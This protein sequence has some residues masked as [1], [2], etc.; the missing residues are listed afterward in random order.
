MAR[1]ATN[2]AARLANCAVLRSAIASLIFLLFGVGNAA[3]DLFISPLR[4]VFENNERSATV[5]LANQTDKTKTYRLEWT[6]KR[7][8]QDGSY[9][10]FK[11]DPEYIGTS[12]LVRFSPRQVTLAGGEKQSVRLALRRPKN[13]PSGEYRSHLMFTRLGGANRERQRK[14][15]ATGAGIQLFLNL[16]FSIPVIVRH[17]DGTATA[18]ISS[19]RFIIDRMKRLNMEV[20]IVREGGFSTYGD[21][22]VFWQAEPGA[23][24]KKIGALNNVSIYH[25]IAKRR[26]LIILTEKALSSGVVRVVYAGRGEYSNRRWFDHRMQIGN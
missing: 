9:K 1:S 10:D 13:L 8:Q 14:R 23:E 19:A 20:E 2:S 17:G 15:G 21:L 4:V 25:E 6:E 5:V 7:A 24:D 26:S 16:S 12:S 11:P 3:A 18:R 22:S